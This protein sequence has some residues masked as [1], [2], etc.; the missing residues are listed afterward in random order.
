MNLKMAEL[1]VENSDGELQLQK[2][3]TSRGFPSRT[4]AGVTFNYHSQLCVAVAHVAAQCTDYPDEDEPNFWE[5]TEELK[6]LNF[7]S[8]GKQ[9]IAY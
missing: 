2:S 7:D 5:F 9:I 8:L 6:D 3:Y 1:L 4:T